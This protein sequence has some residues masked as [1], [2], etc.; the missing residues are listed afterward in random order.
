MTCEIITDR[1]E[2]EKLLEDIFVSDDVAVMHIDYADVC[3][4]RQLGTFG[5]AIV[6]NVDNLNDNSIDELIN[7]IDALQLSRDT[8][9]AVVGHIIV[10]ENS[11]SL[12]SYRDIMN[13]WD[14]LIRM[15]CPKDDSENRANNFIN[16]LW[17]LSTRSSLP[18]KTMQVHLMVA[19]E[20]TEADKVEDE[21][22]EQLIQEYRQLKYP[23]VD[24]MQFETF[25]SL[26]KG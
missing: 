23:I 3:K 15:R 20:K 17:A 24:L 14:F 9:N 25:D 11:L 18:E 16:C 22:F 6:F 12:L 13:L 26:D 5:Q 7:A 2:V 8:L 1:F 19:F 4:L 10:N 21:K